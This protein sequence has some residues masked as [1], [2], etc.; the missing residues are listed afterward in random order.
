MT[1]LPRAIKYRREGEEHVHRWTTS[2]G[3]N[4]KLQRFEIESNNTGIVDLLIDRCGRRTSRISRA[5]ETHPNDPSRG[6]SR[7]RR[8]G[9]V[10][11]AL[12]DATVPPR[13]EFRNTSVRRRAQ[14][15]VVDF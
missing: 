12:V 6:D 4:I 3:L 1:S 7:R 10:G 14:I 9:A 8:R 15:K 13:H 5:D 11:G 2:G